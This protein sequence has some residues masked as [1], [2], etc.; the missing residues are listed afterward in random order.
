MTLD[1]GLLLGP[2][3][4]EVQ[5]GVGGMGEVYRARDTR[6]GRTPGPFLSRLDPLLKNLRD[7]PRFD[8]LMTRMKT[9]WEGFE[10]EVAR[11]DRAAFE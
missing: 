3:E 11:E 5:L 7:T 2:Y 8:N 1:P 9:R 6:L 4:I 10:A